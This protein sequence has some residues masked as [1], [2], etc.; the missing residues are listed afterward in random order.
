[1]LTACVS[2]E[3]A[4]PNHAPVLLILPG[5][6]GGSHDAYPQW[7]AVH[8][9]RHGFRWEAH[10]S[11]FGCPCCFWPHLASGM[12][13]LGSG[14]SARLAMRQSSFWDTVV[15]LS[16]TSAVSG[17]AGRWSSMRAAQRARLSPP[18]D[19]TAHPTQARGC[20]VKRVHYVKQQLL[21]ASGRPVAL[22]RYSTDP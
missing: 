18:R 13:S 5:L 14:C 20:S 16:N 21:T 9:L 22:K 8:G 4:L 1:M 15:E 7:A 19:S 3:Q 11:H 17:I 6:T 2:N 12:T 10:R